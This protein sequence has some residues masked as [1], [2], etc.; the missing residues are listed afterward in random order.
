MTAR[1]LGA[2][3][4]WLIGVLAALV[5][6]LSGAV[7][8]F[9]HV[10]RLLY[11][12]APQLAWP[13]H[14]AYAR[15][16]GAEDRNAAARYVAASHSLPPGLAADFSASGGR[17]F[18]VFHNGALEL[19]HYPVGVDAD[20]RWNSFSLVKSLIGALLFKAVADGKIESLDAPIGRFLPDI[21]DMALRARPLRTFLDMTSGIAFEAA[22]VKTISGEST[23]DISDAFA[24]P[25]SSMA[26][27]HASG[28]SAVQGRLT[29]AA[30]AKDK[31]DYQ[32][33]NTTL[34]GEVLERVYGRSLPEI[35][36]DL[37]WRPAG[38]APAYWRRHGSEGSI[39]VY[40]CLYARPR[41]WMLV[42]LHISRNGS[43]QEPFLPEP[44]WR[45]FLGLDLDAATIARG[46]YANHLRY[47]VLDRPGEPLQG[48]FAYFIG[49]GGQTVYLMPDKDLVV[50][51]FGDRLQRLHSTLYAAWR[52]VTP[53]GASRAP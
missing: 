14:G 35:L 22:G 46:H 16:P 52:A 17:A 30:A 44:L 37:I 41:D 33:I 53:A 51:R 28:L 6:G 36:A 34:L 45:S 7:L 15:V 38:A 10:P 50:V 24:N 2:A 3:K 49:S 29:I 23:K 4:P 25:F 48:R 19:E 43:A 13:K 47:D 39:T 8:A 40:C 26:Q 18:L 32:N 31:F 12:G 42:A 27:L 9:P 1:G 11:E 21:G 5:A 20:T